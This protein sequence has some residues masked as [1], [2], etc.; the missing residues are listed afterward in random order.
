M[1]KRNFITL[2][3][4]I[5]IILLVLNKP[6]FS[7]DKQFKI[8]CIGFY[9]LEN[10]F[11]TIED[12]TINDE[13]FLPEGA[14]KWTGERYKAKLK[15]MSEVIAQIGGEFVKGGPII[16]GLS[17]VE[18]INVVQDLINTPLLKPMGYGIVHYDSPDKRGVDVA[19]IYQKQFFTV[20]NSLAVKLTIPGNADF[21]SRDQLVVSG[22]FDGEPLYVIVNH[23]PSRSGGEKKSAPLRNTAA[24]LCRSIVD[25]IMK[26]DINA[27]IIVMGDLNDDPTNASLTKYLN[28]KGDI[29]KVAVGDLFNPGYKMFKKD[30]IGSLAY[31]DS[32]NLFDQIIVS[33]GL[34]GE[35][36]TNYKFYKSFVYNKKFLTQSEG[37]YSG[38]PLRTYAGGVYQGGYS[39]HFPAYIFLI[40]EKK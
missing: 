14:N 35:D 36:K 39:D 31:R 11:D 18:N 30:G 32:W 15:N 27:K 40:K 12:P 4:I 26:I 37:A 20:T 3:S 33:S 7:Q 1:M 23:W 2:I 24:K 34:I 5:T 16:M 6:V 28:A 29:K 13:E 22:I 9:N 17:E 25:S 10:L 21:F 19:L 8:G 38:Y